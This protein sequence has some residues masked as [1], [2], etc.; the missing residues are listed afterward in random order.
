MPVLVEGVDMF[1]TSKALVVEQD[2]APNL[3]YGGGWR[4]T[5]DYTV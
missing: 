1:I 4:V 2:F 5:V 3:T